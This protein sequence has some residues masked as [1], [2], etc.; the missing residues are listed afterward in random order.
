[1]NYVQK[2]T[3][4]VGL[5][6]VFALAIPTLTLAEQTKA[7]ITYVSSEAI[8][9]N[10]GTNHGLVIGDSLAVV[11]SGDTLIWL[12]ITNI[13]SKS[14]ATAPT[15]ADHSIK[16]GDNVVFQVSDNVEDTDSVISVKEVKSLTKQHDEST[17]NKLRGTVT[18][19][20]MIHRDQTGSG[21]HWY[22]PG[23]GIRLRLDNIGGRGIKFSMRHRTRLYHR[24]RTVRAGQASDDWTHRL[25][26]FSFVS[27]HDRS[28]WGVGRIAVPQVR[29][30]GYIDG[31]FLVR[32]ISER[33][34]AGIAIGASPRYTDSGFDFDRRKAGLFVAYEVGQYDSRLLNLSAALSSE[35]R[36]NTISRDFVYLQSIFSSARKLYLYQS[37]EFDINRSWRYTTTGHRFKLTNY[38]G[39]ARVKVTKNL[40]VR[41]SYDT[42]SAIRYFDSREIADSLFDDRS[43]YGLRGS[44]EWSASDLV[45]ISIDGGVRFRPDI[46]GNTHNA[47]LAVRLKGFPVLHQSLYFRLSWVE[48]KFLTAYRP[49]LAYRFRVGRKWR[50]SLAGVGYIYE[51]AGSVSENFTLTADVSRYFGHRYYFTVQLR[52]HLDSTLRSTDLRTEL[53][54]TL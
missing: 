46:N 26:E 43:R 37:A 11:R 44:V 9:I 7:E 47:S 14:A 16:A 36:G 53:G 31:A 40:N 54:I 4:A 17:E 49:Y 23:V 45:R 34:Q 20:Q 6:V 22:Q 10:V 27:D 42:R 28:I 5:A 50:L 33:W 32:P 1:M 35:Y 18:L 12:R 25:S 3:L 2:Q 38:F 48:T 24:S 8:Y 41:L 39:S 19:E 21:R 29:G 52:E 30:M 13:S 51:S 15:S